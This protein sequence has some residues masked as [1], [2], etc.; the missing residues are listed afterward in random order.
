MSSESAETHAAVDLTYT[1]LNPTPTSPLTYLGDK[2]TAALKQ[3]A[4]IFNMSVPPQATPPATRALQQEEAPV[5]PLRVIGT[6]TIQ[7]DSR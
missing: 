4:S 3:L 1:L 5:P 7:N 6:V 2:H